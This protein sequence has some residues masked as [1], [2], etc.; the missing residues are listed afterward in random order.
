MA[1]ILCM[2]NA[3]ARTPADGKGRP[4]PGLSFSSAFGGRRRHTLTA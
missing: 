4:E 2:A 1:T 3:H